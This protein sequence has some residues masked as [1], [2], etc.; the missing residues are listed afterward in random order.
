MLSYEHLQDYFFD[1]TGFLENGEIPTVRPVR[2]GQGYQLT[3][4]KTGKTTSRLSA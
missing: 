1:I 2:E 3:A 4:V